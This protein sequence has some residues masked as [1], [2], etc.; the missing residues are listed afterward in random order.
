MRKTWLWIGMLLITLPA[1][2]AAQDQHERR[3]PPGLNGAVERLFENREELG[4]TNDQLARVREIK[5][6]SD[7]KN[8]P[9]WQRIMTI[10]R[11]L[12]A[13]D[14]AN[15]QMSHEQRSAMVRKSFGEIRNLYDE[16]WSNERE[17]M[18]SVSRVLSS[19]QKR[20]LR[21]MI[22]RSEPEGGGNNGP[23]GRGDGR[24]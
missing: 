18:R 23:R 7:T 3:G 4:L 2:L 21:E 10:R 9:S 17:A 8:H 11:E 16:I 5:E 22:D 19:E 14:S 12:Q 15:P 6:Q 20:M 13:R 1:S 24:N